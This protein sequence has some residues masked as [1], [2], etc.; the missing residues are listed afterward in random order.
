MREPR[1]RNNGFIALSMTFVPVAVVTL[2]G[3]LAIVAPSPAAATDWS[4]YPW[5]LEREGYFSFF[6]STREQ[7]E[8]TARAVGGCALNPSVLFGRARLQPRRRTI[9]PGW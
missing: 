8:A 5:C 6:Y 3:A 2:A 7:C 9:A 1:S 4:D